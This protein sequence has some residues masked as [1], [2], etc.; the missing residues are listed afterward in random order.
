MADVLVI[1]F[2]LLCRSI[3]YQHLFMSSQDV[4]KYRLR[5]MGI[6]RFGLEKAAGIETA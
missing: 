3:V 2:G 4:L 5:Q 6:E 1:E